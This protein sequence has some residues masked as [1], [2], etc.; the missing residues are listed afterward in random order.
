MTLRGRQICSLGSSYVLFINLLK[1]HLTLLHQS[2]RAPARVAWSCL[3]ANDW[4]RCFSTTP[5]PTSVAGGPEH[6]WVNQQKDSYHCH[7]FYLQHHS[8]THI[9]VVQMK[10]LRDGPSPAVPLRFYQVFFCCPVQTQCWVLLELH[11][12]NYSP[13]EDIPCVGMCHP[14]LSVAALSS[15]VAHDSFCMSIRA[16]WYLH[17]NSHSGIM[18]MNDSTC[19][20]SLWLCMLH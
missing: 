14:S 18:D 7:H 12:A 3:P 13:V 1:R 17:W 8:G 10:R 11:S 2:C 5:W 20:A 9:C 4:L 6:A 15:M 16:D 19:R